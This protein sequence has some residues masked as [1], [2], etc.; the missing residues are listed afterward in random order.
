MKLGR[1]DFPK[2]R[3]SLMAAALMLAA[4]TVAVYLSHT[5][6]EAA[7]AAR[8]AAIAERNEAEGKL[9]QVRQEEADIRQ[10]SLVFKALEARGVIGDE[11]RLEWVELLKDLRGKYRL[12]DL[13]YEIMPQRQLEGNPAG[14]FIFYAS[15][16]KLHAKLLHEEDLTRLIGDLRRDARAL[17]RVRICN[18]ARLSA[19]TEER[20]KGLANLSADCEI[21]WLTLRDSAAR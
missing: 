5:N 2:L 11:Q 17:I 3:F 10:R 8:D 12:A 14:G 7:Q 13:Q 20:S 15:S 6:R 4:G 21:D 18:L 1:A 9:Q 16:M 19:E